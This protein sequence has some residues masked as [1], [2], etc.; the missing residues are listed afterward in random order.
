MAWLNICST[1]RRRRAQK[2]WMNLRG[3]FISF[4]FTIQVYFC[5]SLI[6]YVSVTIR[7]WLWNWPTLIRTFSE[8]LSSSGNAYNE[9]TTVDDVR[10]AVMDWWAVEWFLGRSR[11]EYQLPLCTRSGH[12]ESY[13]LYK[14][15]MIFVLSG[16][17]RKDKF[18]CFK[19]L[20]L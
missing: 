9:T 2:G 6:S 4:N 7:Q 5:L 8:P 20:S 15:R 10:W 19:C 11:A 18:C 14:W 12:Q 13:G 1:G 17:N 16:H 3:S